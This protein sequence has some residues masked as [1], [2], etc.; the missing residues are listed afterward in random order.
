MAQFQKG[1]SGNPGGR[2]KGIERQVREQ[3]AA[4]KSTGKD[5]AEL[6]GWAAIARRLYET[7]TGVTVGAKAADENT[8]AK[9]LYERG[10]G[11]ARETVDLSVG[12]TPEQQAILEA[13][14]LTPLQ[15]A[16]RLREIADGDEDPEIDAPEPTESGGDEPG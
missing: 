2:P 13:L 7:A 6:D 12:V 4:Y 9:L 1:Q 16:A 11:R 5:G 14:K 8:A 10:Y 3:I 15:R